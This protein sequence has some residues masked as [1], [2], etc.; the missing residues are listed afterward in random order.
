VSINDL[1]KRPRIVTEMRL[2]GAVNFD[3]RCGALG[4]VADGAAAS[5]SLR[6]CPVL[7]HRA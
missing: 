6:V 7:Q 3:A 2:F 1:T 4:A 5:Q